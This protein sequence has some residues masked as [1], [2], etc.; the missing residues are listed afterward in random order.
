MKQAKSVRKLK[1]EKLI[2]V[3]IMVK[4]SLKLRIEPNWLKIELVVP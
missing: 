3:R 4:T 2:R 1:K